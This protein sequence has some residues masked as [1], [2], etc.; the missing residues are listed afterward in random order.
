[1]INQAPSTQPTPTEVMNVALYNTSITL[2]EAYR[3]LEAVPEFKQQAAVI[4]L[5]ARR[6]V[7]IIV[8]ADSKLSV[9]AMQDILGEIMGI[10][11][12]KDTNS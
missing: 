6:M 10:S 3:H 11:P 4:L 12:K 8:P 2:M 1:M 9:A 5:M 7:D